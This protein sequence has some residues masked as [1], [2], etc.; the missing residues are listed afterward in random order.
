MLSTL[1]LKRRQ[2]RVT[3]LLVVASLALLLVCV[4]RPAASARKVHPAV[5]ESKDPYAYL[6]MLNEMDLQQML[7][8]KTHGQ[9]QVSAFR[10]KEELIAAVRKIEER[11]DAEASFDA[12]VTAAMERKAALAQQQRGV[13]AAPAKADSEVP[14][15]SS[16]RHQRTDAKSNTK[17]TTEQTSKKKAVHLMDRDERSSIGGESHRQ[18]KGYATAAAAAGAGGYAGAQREP[19]ERRSSQGH[20]LQVLYCTG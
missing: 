12:R 15:L 4:A 16:G 6:N 11:E 20:E 2:R 18:G 1:S 7:H 3:T 5:D 17:D 10:N 14:S 8:E 19:T 9:V 13:E